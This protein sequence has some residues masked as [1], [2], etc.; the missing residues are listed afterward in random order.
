MTMFEPDFDP[1]MELELIKENLNNHSDIINKL[2]KAN[3]EQA[4]TLQ[5]ISE[6]FVKITNQNVFLHNTMN[7]II[8]EI[9]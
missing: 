6:Q 1:L 7:E 8:N 3:N 2:V 5:D 4:I 9:K